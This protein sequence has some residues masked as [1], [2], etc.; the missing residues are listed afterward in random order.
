MLEQFFNLYIFF[1]DAQLIQKKYENKNRLF[2]DNK[3]IIMSNV[4][5]LKIKKNPVINFLYSDFFFLKKILLY[6]IIIN[7]LIYL[8]L[9]Y[10]KKLLVM[11]FF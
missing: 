1:D 7:F 4:S 2:S 11:I 10:L 3:K 5:L 8:G 9:F 6:F